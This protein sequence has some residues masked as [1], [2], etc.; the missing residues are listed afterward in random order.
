[1]SLNNFN[2]LM[3]ILAGLN[4]AP[5][6]RL[7]RTWELVPARTNSALD[8]LKQHMNPTRNFA[9]YRES[10]HSID[11][12]CV[13][14]LGVYLTDLTFID[15][16]NPDKLPGTNLINFSKYSKCAEVISE[17]QQY[18]KLPYFLTTVNDIQRFL[19]QHLRGGRDVVDFYKLS[20]QLEPRERE[21][22]KIARLLHESGF[23]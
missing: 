20:L 11:P 18:Q 9:T 12:P 13:P 15:D 7:K 22:E 17:I 21:D 2:S 4:S 3:A 16:G 5:I 1:M 8:S 19:D 6:H 14:F 10:L 23:L